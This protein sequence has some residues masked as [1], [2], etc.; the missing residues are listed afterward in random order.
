MATVNR[1]RKKAAPTPSTPETPAA[2]PLDEDAARPAAG[3][4]GD[5]APAQTASAAETATPAPAA[6]T[7]ATP[8]AS[9][10]GAPEQDAALEHGRH[11]AFLADRLFDSLAALH[12]LGNGWRRRLRLAALLHDI[13]FAEGRKRHHKTSMRMIDEDKSLNIADKDRPLVA[14]LARYHRKAWPSLKHERFADLSGRKRDAIRKAA[15]LLRVADGLDYRHLGNVQ[16]IEAEITETR[17]RLHLRTCGECG[18]ER[19]RALK[20]GDL[21]EATFDRALECVCREA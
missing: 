16:D 17:I 11:V 19:E 8:D 4:D 6:T 20:K 18:P 12:G 9:P 10:S 14:L 2:A 21:L 1:R 5:A 7:D 3:P 15:A 13:G